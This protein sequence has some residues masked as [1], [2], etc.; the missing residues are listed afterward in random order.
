V[1]GICYKHILCPYKKTP[2]DYLE[3]CG[4]VGSL[5]NRN[6]GKPMQYYAISTNG[7]VI[8]LDDD[9]HSHDAALRHAESGPWEIAGVFTADQIRKIQSQIDARVNL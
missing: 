9:H 2:I 1:G 4:I 5:P 6:R 7:D 3:I 8:D